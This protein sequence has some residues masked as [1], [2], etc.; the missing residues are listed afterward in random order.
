MYANLENIKGY[1][2]IFRPTYKIFYD[3]IEKLKSTFVASAFSL[4]IL[5]LNEN[6]ALNIEKDIKE[7]Y[8]TNILDRY[9]RSNHFIAK[10]DNLPV[11]PEF[12]DF[13]YYMSKQLINKLNKDSVKMDDLVSILN[14]ETEDYYKSIFKSPKKYNDKSITVANFSCNSDLKEILIKDYLDNSEL[15][16]SLNSLCKRKNI[17][18]LMH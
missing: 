10:Q 3:I 7:I 17:V 5:D 16:F 14:Y 11:V 1:Y 18:I 12:S 8:I 2:P 15:K 13:R 6:K 4:N 9:A